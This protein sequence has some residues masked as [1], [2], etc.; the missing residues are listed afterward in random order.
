M[1][2]RYF[3]FRTAVRCCLAVVALAALLVT[4]IAPAFAVGGTTGTVSGTVVDASGAPVPNAQVN[5]AAATGSY[6][7]LTSANGHFTFTGVVTDTYTLS[8]TKPGSETLTQAG[9]TVS[10][11][12]TVTL[13]NLRLGRAL[14]I[15]GTA[16]AN[17][18]SSAYQPSQTQDA[19]TFSGQQVTEA[20]G[21]TFATNQTQLIAS[22]PGTQIDRN[23][24]LSVRGALATETGLNFDGIDY[25]QVDHGGSTNIFLNGIASV[26]VNPGA[27]DATQ[28]ST[29]AG[30]INL[31]PKR[32]THPAFGLLDL[33]AAGP[34][35]NHQLGFE[36][37]WASPNNRFSNYASFT[38]SN[39]DQPY[40][41]HGYTLQQVQAT[42]VGRSGLSYASS[43]Y[44]YVG[45]LAQRNQDVVDNF[46]YRFGTDNNKSIQALYQTHWDREYGGI[47]GVQYSYGDASA[48][49]LDNVIGADP[50]YQPLASRFGPLS[51]S[52]TEANYYGPAPTSQ[53]NNSQD[54]IKL[55]YNQNFGPSTFLALRYYQVNQENAIFD[56]NGTFS[57]AP[58]TRAGADELDGGQRNGAIAELTHQFAKHNVTLGLKYE[59]QRGS[60]AFPDTIGA[61]IPTFGASATAYSFWQDFALPVNTAA[62]SATPSGNSHARAASPYPKEGP[63]TVKGLLYAVLRRFAGASCR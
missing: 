18:A 32:G 30:V 4:D 43:T 23:G 57:T 9:I 20:L 25:T 12:Q 34:Y 51:G 48:F 45:Q 21:K 10:G 52:Q 24:N 8:V 42:A 22:S 5:L 49:A 16:R 39:F 59:L 40:G 47:G 50:A 35:F 27:G 29:G 26:T 2:L 41:P 13:N 37:G 60:F 36:Y 1:T 62:P 6:R 38:G 11:D 14:K 28:G 15:I 55:E 7:T 33:E 3:A 58:L 46:V 31:I 19:F 53:I 17:S 54:L 44:P 56:P 61:L 63:L